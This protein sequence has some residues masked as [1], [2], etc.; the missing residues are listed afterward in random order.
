MIEQAKQ[1]SNFMG[2]LLIN[3]LFVAN[4]RLPTNKNT[5]R[6]K[7][8]ADIFIFSLIFFDLTAPIKD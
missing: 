2:C 8:R 3:E 7:V 5:E 4:K 6:L 1:G